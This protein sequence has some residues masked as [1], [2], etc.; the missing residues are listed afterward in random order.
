MPR[1]AAANRSL[2]TGIVLFNG[3]SCA[4]DLIGMGRSGKPQTGYQFADQARYLDAWLDATD[5]GSVVLTGLSEKD[6]EVYHQPFP[7]PEDRR[8]L[9]EW[10][11]DAAGRRAR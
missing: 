8:L 4:S 7:I 9:L 3:R 6:P 5:L 2:T 11:R 1:T 10:P